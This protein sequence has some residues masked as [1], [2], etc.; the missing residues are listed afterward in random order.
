VAAR[1]E[2]RQEGPMARVR[3]CLLVFPMGMEMKGI[4]CSPNPLKYFS[5]I[6]YY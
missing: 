1:V 6:I 5:L 4:W 2:K 3:P